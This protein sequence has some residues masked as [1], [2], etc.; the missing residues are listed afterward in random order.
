MLAALLS[1]CHDSKPAA[2][3]RFTLTTSSAIRAK[4]S[5]TPAQALG[6][7]TID[8]NAW[9]RKLPELAMA[10]GPKTS[11]GS[12]E[13][14]RNKG[15]LTI[16][17]FKAAYDEAAKVYAF[18]EFVIVDPETNATAKQ[19]EVTYERGRYKDCSLTY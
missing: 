3:P 4:V 2:G 17:I 15:D 1:G 7:T 6:R 18:K 19:M 14:V 8:A 9:K 11:L 16:L 10:Y 13:S 5:E 12:P